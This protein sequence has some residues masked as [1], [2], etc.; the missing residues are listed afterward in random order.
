MVEMEI[1]GKYLDRAIQAYN[2]EDCREV[3]SP[4]VKEESLDNSDRRQLLMRRLLGDGYGV[5]DAASDEDRRRM[6]H[7]DPV[8]EEESQ[9]FLSIAALLNFVTADTSPSSRCRRG[10]GQGHLRAGKW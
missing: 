1:D 4:S 3:V 8:G 10:E 5:S 7:G 9:K 2:L 6:V